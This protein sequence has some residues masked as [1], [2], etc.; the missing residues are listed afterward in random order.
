MKKI[1]NLFKKRI[2]H[3]VSKF[4]KI[5]I[6]ESDKLG[7][8][9]FLD[10][11]EQFSEADEIQ[12]HNTITK[13]PFLIH[14]EIESVL[15]IGGGDGAT[16]RDCLKH[17]NVKYID[18]CEIDKEVIEVCRQYFPQMTT[19]FDD[20]KVNLVIGDGKEFVKKQ[21]KA[22]DL[23]I[24]DSTDP[25][26]HSTPLFEKEFYQDVSNILAPNGLLIC[27]VQ[28]PATHPFVFGKVTDAFYEIFNDIDFFNCEYNRGGV[29]PET[30]LFS[31]CS[32]EEILIPRSIEKYFQLD[33][34]EYQRVTSFRNRFKWS[35]EKN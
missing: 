24:I 23:I 29:I 12:Y 26:N 3:K 20:P 18:Q 14:K 22:Y 28:T 19:S 35:K 17:Q 21:T 33:K 2:F 13:V 7:K 25:I 34:R 4:Q 10:G 27:Q 11:V 5:E 6:L 15:I 1:S 30:S 9:L 31:I 16:A 32:N 8:A